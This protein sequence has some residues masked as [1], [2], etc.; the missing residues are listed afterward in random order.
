MFISK[1]NEFFSHDGPNCTV[2]S[3]QKV[4]KQDCL[5]ILGRHQHVKSSYCM[6]R[7][8]NHST[9]WVAKYS[10]L[11]AFALPSALYAYDVEP[12]PVSVAS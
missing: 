12:E 8:F 4:E 9:S 3:A 2:A 5:L 6:Q 11:G 10:D 1:N 7:N